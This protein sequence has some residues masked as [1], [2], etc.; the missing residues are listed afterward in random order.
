[1]EV[2][3]DLILQ[4]RSTE[5]Q[6]R[7][8]QQGESGFHCLTELLVLLGM[9]K[10]GTEKQQNPRGAASVWLLPNISPAEGRE[11]EAASPHQ[12]GEGEGRAKPSVC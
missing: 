9:H 11:R 2:W 8:P 7:E 4:V 5:P 10:E 3:L 12:Q 6:L 1:M